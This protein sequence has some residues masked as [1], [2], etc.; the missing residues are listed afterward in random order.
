MTN[1]SKAKRYS[2]LKQ[3]KANGST[4]TPKELADFVSDKLLE[5]FQS[6]NPNNET[7]IKVFDPSLGDGVLTFSLIE[8]L[9]CNNFNHIELL[10]LDI[11]SQHFSQIEKDL[12]QR[13]PNISFKLVNDD[14]YNFYTN[15]VGLIDF[16]LII[17]NPPYIRT[18][19]MGENKSK[20]LA[21]IFKIKGKVDAY[22]AFMIGL[23]NFLAQFGCM[24]TI[25]SNKFL[26][27]K[28]GESVREYIGK[29]LN[30]RE[31]YDLG[32]TKI[33]DGVA[34]LPAL[35]FSQKNSESNTSAT[36]KSLYQVKLN[37]NKTKV[38]SS[39][40][41]VLNAQDSVVAQVG[42][43]F[44][45][46]NIGKL[47][48]QCSKS[49]VWVLQNADSSE[50]LKRVESKTWHT[51]DD[52]F[53][54][55]VGVKST[56]DKVFIKRKSEWDAFDDIP[57][58]LQDL[59]TSEHANNFVANHP[60]DPKQIIYP[61]IEVDGEKKI[62]SLED[63][64]NTS[65]YF[66][67][68]EKVLKSRDYLIKSKRNWYELWVPQDVRLWKYSKVIWTDISEKP[69]FW[70][71]LTGKVVN[72]ECFWLITKDGVDDDI[73]WLCLGVANSKFIEKYY[74]VKFNNKLFSGKRR[75]VK[76]YV[77][78]FPLPNPYNENSLRII[79]LSK[80]IVM[81]PTHNNIK[82]IDEINK[83]VELAFLTD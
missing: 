53:N 46:L 59:I 54:I 27:I 75:F 72:G 23:T 61:H 66:Y 52:V 80:E 79:E 63:N 60:K 14:F 36:F 32:D 42:E 28:S 47:D 1:T 70:I 34:V 40:Y 16:D 51:F 9:V 29:H 50:W 4:Y 82:K 19:I 2:N 45:Q 49:D 67:K 6:N 69:K 62:A 83:L 17:A 41:D 71:D 13:Y 21:N 65:K 76:Q 30:I 8:K 55:K 78:N 3:E 31:I 48:Y 26:T 43:N 68:N 37:D 12:I 64:P 73:L 33:F 38:Y 5:M 18:Q 39:I 74:D 15:N 22:Q 20:E 25:T 56:A 10:G 58:L 44:Y 57:E 81:K 7:K 35:V 24:A 11:D 77:S